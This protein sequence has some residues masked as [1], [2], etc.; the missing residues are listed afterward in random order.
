MN[1]ILSIKNLCVDFETSRRTI[2]ALNGVNL[3]VQE[4]QTLGVVGESGCGKSVTALATIGLLPPNAR[5]MTG[6]ILFRGRD[7]LKID[8]REMTR[9]RSSQVSMVFQDPASSFDPLFRIED[10]VAEPFRYHALG[11]DGGE[12]SKFN[13]R[14]LHEKIIR[15]LELVRIP[16]PERVA[17]S[18]PHQLSGGMKQRVMIAIALALD[19][20][21]VILDEPTTA[22]DVTVQDE[23]L[24][25][26]AEIKD[27][28]HTTM[29]LITHDFGIVAEICDRVA[30]MYAGKV[31]ETSD[32][33][34]LLTEPRHPYTKGLLKSVPS[35]SSEIK[36]LE[37][38]Q[39]V[40][41]D[42]T[43]L[44]PGCLFYD[45]CPMAMP[46]CNRIDPPNILVKNT[47]EVKCHLYGTSKNDLNES[48]EPPRIIDERNG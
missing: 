34:D 6:Q 28:L 16:D 21:I 35:L 20:K 18:Y 17:M 37:S 46:V 36:D 3:E 4:G 13:K 10:Q 11:Q 15:L 42:L 27:R 9:L 47:H 23:I 45:R 22:L 32:T 25:L 24:S 26:L 7:L 8:N 5:V 12:R 33:V 19:P 48:V 39:G 40:V 44:P 30:V 14:P 38:I 1:T 43:A 41:P 2:R 29:L 31:V